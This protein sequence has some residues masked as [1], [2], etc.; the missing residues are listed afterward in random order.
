MLKRSC[1]VA[2]AIL[3]LAASHERGAAAGASANELSLQVWKTL[4][5][6]EEQALHDYSQAITTAEVIE[7]GRKLKE[8][9]RTVDFQSSLQSCGLAAQT[10]SDMVT[11]HYFSRRRLAIPV[12]WHRFSG[13]YIR[14]RQAC[15]VDLSL[16]EREH[17]LPTWFGK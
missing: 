1:I 3:T 12:D 13:D 5:T 4:L 8:L 11:N 15:L 2:L 17:S 9:S 7:N 14:Y 16:D 6:L 10:L